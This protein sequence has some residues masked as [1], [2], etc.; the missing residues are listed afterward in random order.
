MFRPI[1]R[2]AHKLIALYKTYGGA[3]ALGILIIANAEAELTVKPEVSTRAYYDNNPRVRVDPPTE[4]FATINEVGAATI[5]SR[6]TYNVS[7]A[8]KFRLSRYTEETELDSE[9]YFVTLAA[10]KVFE[11]HQLSSEFNYSREASFT[12][13]QTDSDRFNVNVPRT[14]FF[15]NSSWLY[16]VTDQLNLTLIGNAIDVSFE[17]APAGRLIDYS[18][19]SLGSFLSYSISDRTNLVATLNVSEFKTPQI[20][21][22]TLSYAFQ[23]GFEKQFY[24]SLHASF[25]IGH[26]ISYIGFQSTQTQIISQ[27]PP[28]F[29][30]TVMSERRRSS[31]EIIDLRVEKEFERANVSFEWSRSFSPSSDGS[32]Q[33]RQEVD[34]Y[35]RYRISQYLD[36]ALQVQYRESS[37]EG[38]VNFV[39]PNNRD[40]IMVRGRL[41]Y[42]ISRYLQGEFGI[43]YRQVNRT[44]SGTNSDSERLFL[45]LRYRPQESHYFQ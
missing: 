17:D 43:Q 25:R 15:L 4:V 14:S 2:I 13:E 31:G 36:A 21:S 18:Q 33:Q 24:E 37:Q 39:R 38:Q 8:P 45:A 27:F 35:G 28:Q 16:A 5:Y 42:R 9:D 26:N 34:G 23:I 10:D 44:S 19:F 40:V 30:T 1:V 22:E 41:I 20:G 29:A 6:P 12:T 3:L 7:L 32:R 11:R